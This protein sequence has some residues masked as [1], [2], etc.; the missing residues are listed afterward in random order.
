MSSL[1]QTFYRGALGAIVMYDITSRKSFR[2]INSW[3]K[4][5]NEKCIDTT[6]QIVVC[7]N[8]LDLDHSRGVAIAD[9]EFY[10]D[11]KGYPFF[12]TSALDGTNVSA[13]FD[14][15]IESTL[16]ALQLVPSD[17]PSKRPPPLSIHTAHKQQAP[18][19][20]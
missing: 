17:Q 6:P 12:E 15:L 5:L 1:T 2:E 20:C 14:E 7:G 18:C 11:A 10:C 16:E 13:A 19:S 4:E 8:K 3:V 9:A